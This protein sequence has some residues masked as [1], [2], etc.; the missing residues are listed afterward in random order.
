M[1]VEGAPAFNF[2]DYQR[3]YVHFRR[4][5]KIVKRINELER[6]LKDL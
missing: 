2:S 5:D 6:K 3:S 1:V 4:F